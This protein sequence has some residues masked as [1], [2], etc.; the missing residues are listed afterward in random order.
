MTSQEQS[1]G[2]TKKGSQSSRMSPFRRP[3]G[4]ASPSPLRYSTPSPSNLKMYP[5]SST[6][7]FSHG[8]GQAA[9]DTNLNENSLKYTHTKKKSSSSL[10][11]GGSPFEQS[12]G[13]FGTRNT[14][15][16]N[17]ISK[18]Q[19]SQ[20]RELREAFQILDRDSDGFV[21]REDI[22]D[23][24]NQLGLFSLCYKTLLADLGR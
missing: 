20:V 13:V 23:M 18:L 16:R 12:D 17:A 15:D 14:T 10:N 24:L 22:A 11:R 4:I 2:H 7:K 19:P 9:V 6:P 5:T 3:E 21:G 8:S 1:C